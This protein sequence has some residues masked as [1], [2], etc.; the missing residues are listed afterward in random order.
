MA[1]EKTEPEQDSC[2]DKLCSVFQD[3][4]KSFSDS[5]ERER[6]TERERKGIIPNHPDTKAEDDTR[7]K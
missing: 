5:P 6:E 3:Y 2:T 4:H 7:K 1:S